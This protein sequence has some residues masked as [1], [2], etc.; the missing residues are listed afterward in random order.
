MVISLHCCIDLQW[1]EQIRKKK[2]KIMGK[3][4][5]KTLVCTG[6]Q[7]ALGKEVSAFK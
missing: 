7:A 4:N 1:K 2:K 3:L 5:V 6:K